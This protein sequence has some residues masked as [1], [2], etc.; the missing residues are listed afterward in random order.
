MNEDSDLHFD[1]FRKEYPVLH[2]SIESSQS[3]FQ[4]SLAA[5]DQLR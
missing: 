3:F 1:G 5:L 2:G 4:K